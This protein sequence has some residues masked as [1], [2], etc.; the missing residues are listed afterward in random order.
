MRTNLRGVLAVCLATLTLS[1]QAVSSFASDR[2]LR[3]APEFTRMDL[4]GRPVSLLSFRGKVVLLNFWATW[5]EPCVSEIPRFTKW[6]STYEAAGLRIVGVSM[7]DDAAAVK[8]AYEK[9]H[10]NYPVV[11]GDAEL[12]ESFGAVLGLPLSYL[13]DPEGRI[14]ARY[15]GEPDLKKLESQIKS[16]LP[17]S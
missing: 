3:M 6:Q 10:L 9:Y 2:P 7:D 4:Q 13:I 1:T 14:V 17:R 12:G 8:W 15:Q 16:L 5:C 11:M